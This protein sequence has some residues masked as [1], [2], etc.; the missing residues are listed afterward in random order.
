MGVGLGETMVV[1]H[2]PWGHIAMAE[3]EYGGSGIWRKW[4]CREVQEMKM[5]E[6]I[7]EDDTL[8]S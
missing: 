7:H 6:K 3:V 4:T 5:V 2:W 8:K 1:G